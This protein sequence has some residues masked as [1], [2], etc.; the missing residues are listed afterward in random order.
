MLKM[1][2]FWP[3]EGEMSL[4]LAPLLYID[5]REHKNETIADEKMKELKKRIDA[6]LATAV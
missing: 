6:N 3:P 2:Q 5:F 1:F 4:P